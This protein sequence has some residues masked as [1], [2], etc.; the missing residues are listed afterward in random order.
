MSTDKGTAETTKTKVAYKHPDF[1]ERS[2]AQLQADAAAF[3]LDDHLVAL[4]FHEP[5]YADIIRSLHKEATDSISTAGVIAKE[6][7]LRMFWNPLFLAAYP[8][9]GVRGILKHEALHLAL[10]HTTQRRYE[11]HTAWNWATDLAI[12]CTLSKE[13]M[14]ECGLLPGRPLKMPTNFNALPPDERDRLTKVSKLIV[15]LPRDLTGEEYFTRLMENEDFKEMMENQEGAGVGVMDDHE[16]WDELSDEQREYVASRVRQVVKGAVD[17]A[18]A[19]NSWG[20]IPSH[21]REEIRK[22]ITGEIDWRALLRQF[23]GCTNRADRTTSV[24]RL[25][26]KYPGIHPGNSRDYK[27]T[28]HIYLDQSGSVPDAAISLFFGELSNLSKQV[29]FKLFYFDTEVDEENMLLWKKGTTPQTLRTRSGGTDFEAP[30]K[31]ALKTKPDGYLILTDGEA[32]KPSHSR[33]RRGWVL[34]PG[35]SLAWGDV[36]GNETVIKMKKPLVS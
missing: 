9:A 8:N 17:R 4:L 24:Y 30:T 20:S 31:H 26:K 25:N 13:E 15:S 18:D 12:N 2:L 16:G 23:V 3:N 27:P 34:V 29:T 6:D 5:F 33:I 28:L 14:P 21:M 10:E 11:P 35:C 7:I 22:R 19:K 36:N 32:S 1:P